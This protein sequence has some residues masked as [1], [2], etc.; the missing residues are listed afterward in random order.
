MPDVPSHPSSTESDRVL[1]FDWGGTLMR[2][3]PRWQ[4]TDAGWTREEAIPHAPETLQSLAKGWRMGLASNACES[5]ED[6]IR[7]SLDTIGI[8]NLFEHIFTWRSVGSPKPWGPF[9]SHVL[10]DLKVAPARVVMVGDDWMGDVWGAR[11]AG[12]CGVWFNPHTDEVRE[13][14]GVRTIHDFRSLPDVLA[15][16]GF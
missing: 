7:A 8:G 14:D 12:L 4:G 11:Q 13:R 2:S 6:P 10:R 1:L 9:W 15:D 3:M 16:L 5:D